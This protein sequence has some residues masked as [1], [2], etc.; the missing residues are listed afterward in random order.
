LRR[1]TPDLQ[2][3]DYR[4]LDAPDGVWA[5]R[6]GTHTVVALN[7][8]DEGAVLEGIDGHIALA[9]DRSRD[10]ESVSGALR[11]RAWEGLVVETA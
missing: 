2:T 9:T 3:G 11:L 6:R 5:W 7:L 4:S 10:G 8:H 1:R